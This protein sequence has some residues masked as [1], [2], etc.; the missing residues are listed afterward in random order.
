MTIF[1]EYGQLGYILP[2]R[3]CSEGKQIDVQF[4][5][6]GQDLVS[7]A[8]LIPNGGVEIVDATDG[9]AHGLSPLGAVCVH[10]PG[11][12]TRPA[13]PPSQFPNKRKYH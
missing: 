11:G 12:A 3:H 2:D 9:A 1:W 6:R 4:L 13:M 8:R 10:T 5:Q 7:L